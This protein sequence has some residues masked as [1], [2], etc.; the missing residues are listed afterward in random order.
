[1]FTDFIVK[2]AH[3]T[4]IINNKRLRVAIGLSLDKGAK[5][6][7]SDTMF[8]SSPVNGNTWTACHPDSSENHLLNKKSKI[9]TG[10]KHDGPIN[11]EQSGNSRIF[12][13]LTHVS[14]PQGVNGN[15]WTACHL[16]GVPTNVLR[17]DNS[18]ILV[19]LTCVSRSHH[20]NVE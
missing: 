5:V 9:N 20:M 12:D 1:M 11:V 4:T 16:Q 2:S 18:L 13:D 15:R 10:E 8:D 19:E 17:A 3:Y 7:R 6:E 14:N